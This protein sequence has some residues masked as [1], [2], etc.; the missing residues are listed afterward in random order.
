[1]P[2]RGTLFFVIAC[3]S[4]LH[5]CNDIMQV[6]VPSMMPLLRETHALSY[7]SLGWVLFAL[8][9]TSA[10]LQPVLG[11][12]SD[13]HPKRW[14]M[15]LAMT[16]SVCGIAL[17]SIASTVGQM[18]VCAVLIGC[19]SA[20][21][22]PEASKY[23]HAA[24]GARRGL[25]Q[26][27]YQVGGNGGTAL[28]PLLTM[29]LFLPY[30]QRAVLAVAGLGVLA[31]GIATR[32]SYGSI[33]HT[34]THVS[35][36]AHVVVHRR[37]VV[38]GLAVLAWLMVVRST[39][40]MSVTQ[41]YQYYVVQTYGT[42]MQDAQIPLFL[43]GAAGVLGTLLGGVWADRWGA[44]NVIVFS[45]AGVAPMALVLPYVPYV[46]VA[47]MLIGIG[48]VL[49]LGF[50]IVV[51]YAQHLLPKHI[52]TASGLIVGFAFGMG[53]LAAAVLGV[54]IDYS[55]LTPA[56]IACSV[57]PLLGLVALWLPRVGA[58]KREEV[59]HAHGR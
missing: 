19:G 48:F 17:L 15:P 5:M 7:T 58:H 3:V 29:S 4:V 22:H 38:F 20:L 16:M 41:Y 23:V 40:F 32:L 44:K 21:F 39:Y 59:S 13:R 55:G 1:V 53:A 28:G 18:L 34:R 35:P 54:V 43:F 2:Q 8:N 42:T 14:L 31:W 37:T 57:F 30:G 47:P 56:T 27:L 45:F 26:S 9:G 25:A 33:A 10:L 50:S 36:S 52:A 24:A 46:F 51:V 11:F 49:M 12:W 6:A